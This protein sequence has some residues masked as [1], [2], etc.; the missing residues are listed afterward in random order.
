MTQEGK[1]IGPYRLEATLGAGGMGT[2][3]RAH[4]DR[5][6]RRVAIK[7]IRHDQMNRPGAIRRFRR[8]AVTL[9]RVNHPYLVQI[10]DL[11]DWEDSYGLVMELVEGVTLARKLEDGPLKLEQ[12]TRLLAEITEGLSA[13]HEQGIAHHDLKAGNV[14]L[15][16]HGHVK[17][18]DF[19]LAQ[20]GDP[21]EE[22]QPSTRGP[23][24]GTVSAMSPEQALGDPVDARSDLFS[25][26]VLA[27]ETLT[28]VRPFAAQS[29]VQ[30]LR[31]I[32]TEQQIPVHE[33][34][35]EVSLELS[36][37]VDHLLAKDPS[38][39]PESATSVLATLGRSSR[40]ATEPSVAFKRSVDRV[41]SGEPD[42]WAWQ[43]DGTASATSMAITDSVALEIPLSLGLV[44]ANLVQWFR[45]LSYQLRPSGAYRRHADLV[46]KSFLAP[47][48]AEEERELVRL[49][50]YLDTQE[51]PRWQTTRGDLIRLR[52]EL[53]AQKAGD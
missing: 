25:L 46:D 13:I 21:E 10:Y 48:R 16:P 5:L 2:V 1:R 26:G 8:E 22:G 40:I 34:Q 12:A 30:T 19:G 3:F 31:N 32:V 38:D 51:V 42:P 14:M 29:L 17:I 24:E 43:Q 18:M 4:D 41:R 39:R 35:P 33:R 15:T 44:W 20:F 28:G 23:L 11:V 36:D 52:D 9:A 53:K 45:F 7:V 50:A 37:L 49:N 6:D 27:Y 47:L